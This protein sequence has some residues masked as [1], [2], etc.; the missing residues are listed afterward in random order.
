MPVDDFVAA[1][2]CDFNKSQLLSTRSPQHIQYQSLRK[3]KFQ[4]VQQGLE[5]GSGPGALLGITLGSPFKI[6]SHKSRGCRS[7]LNR[8]A[9]A[10]TK[11]ST[12]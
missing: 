10:A 6:S 8:K 7:L 5:S 9:F 11:S 3:D 4:Q 12:K 2:A 1:R